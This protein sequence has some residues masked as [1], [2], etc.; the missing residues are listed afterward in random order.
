MWWVHAL[1]HIVFFCCVL[2]ISNIMT[3]PTDRLLFQYCSPL[4]NKKGEKKETQQGT[5]A[6]GTGMSCLEASATAPLEKSQK[7][8]RSPPNRG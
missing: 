3:T 4:E 1:M 7:Q 8:G 5:D 6:T 2:N